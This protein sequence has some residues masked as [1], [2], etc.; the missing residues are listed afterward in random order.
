MKTLHVSLNIRLRP[1]VRPRTTL[2]QGRVDGWTHE[3]VTNRLNEFAVGG[4]FIEP[5]VE[6]H[7]DFFGEPEF[8][9]VFFAGPFIC[10]MWSHKGSAGWCR[11]ST[12]GEPAVFRALF[13]TD[14]TDEVGL[15]A[16]AEGGCHA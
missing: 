5:D 8:E 11:F 14:F 4:E 10:M 1:G 3:Q 13:G 12:F 2:R 7:G 16:K 15:L 9:W 6:P